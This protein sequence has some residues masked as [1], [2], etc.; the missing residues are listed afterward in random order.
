VPSVN[1][2]YDDPHKGCG[3]LVSYGPSLLVNIGFD[4]KYKPEDQTPPRPGIASVEALVDTGAL[5][6]CIDSLLAAQLSLPI[7]DRRKVIGVH[8]AEEVNMHLA[9]IHVPALKFTVHGE[10][11]AVPLVESGLGY[12]ALIGRTFLRHVTMTYD[13][14]TGGVKISY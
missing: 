14:R 4:P 2:G 11:A 3:L 1:C 12:K 13:G 7:F 9:Q 8:G 5:E 10:F 6:S